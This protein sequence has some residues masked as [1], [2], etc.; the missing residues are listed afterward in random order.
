MLDQNT[1]KS[2]NGSKRNTVDHDRTVFLAIS[3]YIFAVKAQRKLEVKLNRTALPCSS[4][5]ILQMEV[6]LRS[7]ECAVAF[8]YHIVQSQIVK[9]A[10]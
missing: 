10:S 9:S 7:I 3:S 1:D 8:I 6:D 4:N 2:F 5:G